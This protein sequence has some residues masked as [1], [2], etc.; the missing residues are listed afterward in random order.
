MLDTVGDYGLQMD[1]E[2]IARTGTKDGSRATPDLARL[3]GVRYVLVNEP[4]KG[5]CFN[6]AL[7]K[8]LTG[9]D[10]INA[11][12]LFG[13]I[14]QFKPLFT[15]FITTNNLP[16][17]ADDTLF[18]SDRIRILPFEKHFDKSER[19]TNLKAELREDNGREAVLKWLI[20]GYRLYRTNGLTDTK[21]GNEILRQ[22]RKDN[23]YVQQ[24][25]DECLEILDQSD[26]HAKPTKFTIIQGI[27]N[28]WCKNANIKPLGLKT[29]REE[30]EKHNIIVDKKHGNQY[31]AK[32]KIKYD[33]AIET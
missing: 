32:V 16:A 20:D 5:T 9:S 13:A 6:E 31:S 21:K 27:Y 14:I 25:I 15:I 33:Y 23:D 28:D 26:K 8:Q 10:D 1:F 22:Y 11:R 3:I 2:T 24:F 30:F 17:I 18:S 29:L 12:P 19:N 4:Q 7:V